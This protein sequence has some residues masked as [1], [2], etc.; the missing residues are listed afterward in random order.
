MTMVWHNGVRLSSTVGSVSLTDPGLLVGDGVFETLAVYQGKVF[1]LDLH[2]HRLSVAL[3]ALE[4]PPLDQSSLVASVLEAAQSVAQMPVAR[5]RITVWRSSTE[6]AVFPAT[7]TVS[8]SVAV[9]PGVGPA[10][11]TVNPARAAVG[12]S[13]FVRNERSPLAGIKSTAYAENIAALRHAR[14][15]GFD[16]ALLFNTVGDLAEGSTTN[17]V[18]EFPD[19]L[20]TPAPSSGALPGVTLAI[21]R[22]AA[23]SS[24]ITLRFAQP[25]ELTPSSLLGRP[26]ALLGTLRNV[27][28]VSHFD[29]SPVDP[30][31]LIP[32][33]AQSFSLVMKQFSH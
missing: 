27:Q 15:A 30:G 19:E 5:M 32:A 11:G 26:L 28:S 12:T 6:L 33:L 29:A 3:T 4:L 1:A 14:T 8:W 16:E 25:G 24:G 9:G 23:Q 22:E 21:A 20:V 18:V 10:C 31:V 13:P 2:L 17:V 7:S